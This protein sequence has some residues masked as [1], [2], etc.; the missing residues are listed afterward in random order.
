[1]KPNTAV[2]ISKLGNSL[3]VRSG[4][5]TFL[6]RPTQELNFSA[7]V[8]GDIVSLTW[9]NSIPYAT[10]RLGKK[11]QKQLAKVADNSGNTIVNVTSNQITDLN[12]TVINIIN[13]TVSPSSEDALKAHSLDVGN[14]EGARIRGGQI[15]DFD[16]EETSPEITIYGIRIYDSTGVPKIALLTGTPETPG[17]AAFLVGAE[18]DTNRMWF[19]DGVLEVVGEINVTT[20][21]VQGDLIVNEAGAIKWASEKWIAD[22]SGLSCTEVTDGDLG[23]LRWLDNGELIARVSA[24][25][26]SAKPL[27][28]LLTMA[29]EDGSGNKRS[30][31]SIVAGNEDGS[32]ANIFLQ[33]QQTGP[34]PFDSSISLLAKSIVLS[35]TLIELM[36]QVLLGSMFGGINIDTS[37][38]MTMVETGTIQQKGVTWIMAADVQDHV[39]YAEV[40]R[41]QKEVYA[42][43]PYANSG[44]ML[45][46]W[47]LPY[48]I[49]GRTV[50]VTKITFYG[51]TSGNSPYFDGIY[52]RRSD[53]DGSYTDDISYTTDIGNGSSGDFSQDIYEGSLELSDFPYAIIVDVAGTGSYYDWIVYGF[54][55]EWTT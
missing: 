54:R 44:Y 11:G 1:M 38:N 18:T 31:I 51:S 41:V 25:L 20:G 19:K 55:I 24:Y 21:T 16:P 17:I 29:Q 7:C 27:L 3:R 47:P 4:S 45:F 14:L 32:S 10:A 48:Q 22:S 50:K 37:G 34:N 6:A 40:A 35:G 43:G 5:S 53:L 12:E 30:G 15:L 42:E 33:S 9:D 49:N 2:I 36:G 8:A 52:L 46:R 26:D 23:G 28:I 13:N 39:S